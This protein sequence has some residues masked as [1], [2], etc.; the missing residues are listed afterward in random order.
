M[1]GGIEVQGEGVGGIGRRGHA[2]SGGLYGEDAADEVPGGSATA[3]L[4]DIHCVR[5][6]AALTDAELT[7]C[8]DFIGNCPLE[9]VLG[10]SIRGSHFK[11]IKG[12][13]TVFGKG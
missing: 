8:G 4:G 13:S 2:G 10:L 3:G 6:R 5:A 1:G 11:I 12:F 7:H 9:G